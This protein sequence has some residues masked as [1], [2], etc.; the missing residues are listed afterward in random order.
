ME[1]HPE[2]LDEFVRDVDAANSR[3]VWGAPDAKSWY[4]NSHGRVSQN[5]PHSL[6][7]Y[8]RRTRRPSP[9]DYVFE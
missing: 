3:I 6:M 1:C 4:K 8:W 9:E 2:A 5:W 7:E